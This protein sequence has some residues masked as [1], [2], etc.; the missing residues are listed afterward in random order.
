MAE[1]GTN[2]RPVRF[3]VETEERLHEIASLCDKNGWIFVGGFE[4][5]EPEDL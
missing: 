5:D 1:L 4:H 3:H 2:K